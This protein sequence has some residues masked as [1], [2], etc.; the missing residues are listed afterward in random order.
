MGKK[1]D[2]T[3]LNRR[4]QQDLVSKYA[5]TLRGDD[6][7]DPGLSLPG[8][9]LLPP[10]P[11]G[12]SSSPKQSFSPALNLSRAAGLAAVESG[13]TSEDLTS[14]LHELEREATGLEERIDDFNAMQK[15][16]KP[17]ELEKTYSRCRDGV[18]NPKWMRPVGCMWSIVVVLW[19][20]AQ[21]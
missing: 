6:D 3:G 14:L 1:D 16:A 7:D 13:P 5:E 20:G 19:A 17:S 9:A 18:F 21:R 8:P 2:H 10:P 12:S 11:K 15:R 4:Q